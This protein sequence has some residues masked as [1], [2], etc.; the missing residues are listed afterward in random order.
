MFVQRLDSPYAWEE[1]LRFTLRHNYNL[2]ESLNTFN[3]I[4]NARNQQ[5]GEVDE[6]IV[7]LANWEAMNH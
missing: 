6:G 1:T 7:P 5:Q 2:Y 4:Q 3:L